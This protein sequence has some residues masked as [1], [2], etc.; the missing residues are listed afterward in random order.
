MAI[1][2]K[3]L[4]IFGLGAAEL[5]AAAPAGLAMGFHPALTCAVASV[6]GIVAATAVV[7]LGE[8]VRVW[9]LRRRKPKKQPGLFDRIWQRYGVVGWGLLAPLLTGSPLGTAIG[10]ALGAPARRLLV[11]ISI[12]SILWSVVF[13]VASTFGFRLFG[14]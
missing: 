3:F 14:H 12:G 13:T 10:L 4:I 9:I 2:G 8:P 6:G 11:W 5:W 1:I 7:L